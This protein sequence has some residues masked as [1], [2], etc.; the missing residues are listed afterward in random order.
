MLSDLGMFW[1]KH[2]KPQFELSKAELSEWEARLSTFRKQ[3]RAGIERTDLTKS[4]NYHRHP[5]PTVAGSCVNRG[6]AYDGG[7]FIPWGTAI[8][9]QKPPVGG[10][11][12]DGHLG[13]YCSIGGIGVAGIDT[14]AGINFFTGDHCGTLQVKSSFLTNGFIVVTSGG[15]G[16]ARGVIT[17]RTAIWGVTENKWIADV[18]LHLADI[19]EWIGQGSS[20]Y[21]N[22]QD[23]VTAS[24]EVESNRV[25]WLQAESSLESDL[26]GGL[27]GVNPGASAEE[28]VEVSLTNMQ[29][30][31]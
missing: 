5:Y 23:D 29:V 28:E 7:N 27:F 18:G 13:G 17:L 26:A 30:C 11:A 14:L 12:I 2:M 24:A 22:E 8:G 3:A 1:P 21:S 10:L 20:I 6:P 4:H 19:F 9:S 15:L 25:Y 16:F 31:L